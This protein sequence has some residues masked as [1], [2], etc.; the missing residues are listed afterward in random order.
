MPVAVEVE[1][2]Q[3]EV[4]GHVARIWL[5]R[6]HKRNSVSQ[7]LLAGARRGRAAGRGRPR[8]S[9]HGLPRAARARSAPASTSTSSRATSSAHRR[10]GRSRSARPASA[11]ASSARRS[12]RSSVLEGYTT[13][14]GFEIMINCDFAIAADDAQDRRLPHAPRALRRGRADLPPASHPRRAEGEGADAH[15]QAADGR[16]GEG[17]GARQRLAPPPTSSTSAS[18]GSSRPSPTRARS[19]C[20]SRR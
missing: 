9:R 20:R 6:P 5:N 10:R 7:Q 3:Y 13:A 4:D 19:R 16:R 8:G 2:I 15:R 14:G 1:P 12:R 17:V 18:T 11:T